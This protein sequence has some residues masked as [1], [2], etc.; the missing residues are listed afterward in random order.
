MELRINTDCFVE[1]GAS[2][3]IV[4][5][6]IQLNCVDGV[7]GCDIKTLA[8]QMGFTKQWVGRAI[9][10]LAYFEYIDVE[11]CQCPDGLYRKKVKVGRKLK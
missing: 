6:Y 11:L 5:A 10:R 7:M 2:A 4:L 1:C 9:E 8:R 3:A